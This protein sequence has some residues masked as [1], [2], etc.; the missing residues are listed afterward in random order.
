MN[1]LLPNLKNKKGMLLIIV[2]MITM[3]VTVMLAALFIHLR[4][5]ILAHDVQRAE[6]KALL[7]AQEGIAYALTEYNNAGGSWSTHDTNFVPLAKEVVL[8]TTIPHPQ[9]ADFKQAASWQDPAVQEWYYTCPIDHDNDPSTAAK[10]V[11]RL[12]AYPSSTGQIII[13]CQATTDS[14]V[15]I[16][17]TVE[18]RLNQASLF[19]YFYFFPTDHT[20]GSATYNGHNYGGIHVNGDILLKGQQNFY[21]LT[22]FSCGSESAGKGYIRTN[23]NSQFADPKNYAAEYASLSSTPKYPAALAGNVFYGINEYHFDAPASGWTQF[24]FGE[25][26]NPASWV[27]GY[28]ERTLDSSSLGVDATWE[29]DKYAGAPQGSYA[30]HFAV[31]DNYLK[32]LAINEL[33]Y[34]STSD[35]S[36]PKAI[37]ENAQQIEFFDPKNNRN[38]RLAEAEAFR[39]AYKLEKEGY[40]INWTD[41]W[42]DWKSNHVSDYSTYYSDGTFSG[43]K[44]QWERRYWMAR[45]NFN[46]PNDTGQNVNWEWWRDLSY[47]DERVGSGDDLF[48]AQYVYGSTGQAYQ[49][50]YLHSGEQANAWKKWV[51]K[52][53]QD[54]L[55]D[56]DDLV[57]DKTL[58]GKNPLLERETGKEITP[59]KPTVAG[60]KEKAQDNGLYIKIKSA[61]H[62]DLEVETSG[63][64][65]WTQ[66]IDD[67]TF[68]NAYNPKRDSSNKYVPS[69]VIK[70]DV[71]KLKEKVDAGE[72]DFNGIVYVENF[73]DTDN[74]TGVML[75]NAESLPAGGLTLTTPLNVYLKGNFNLDPSGEDF[76]GDGKNERPAD[77][78]TVIQ[79]AIER[80]DYL[81]SA[82]DLIWQPA[83]VISNR[84]VYAV[85]DDFPEPQYMPLPNSHNSQYYDY[86]YGYTDQQ[87]LYDPYYGYATGEESE[88]SWMPTPEEVNRTSYPTIYDWFRLSGESLPDRW[89]RQWADSEWGSWGDNKVFYYNDGG[90]EKFILAQDLRNE[91]YDKIGTAYSNEYRYSASKPESTPQL[92]NQ[93]SSKQIYNL[94]IVTPYQTEPY[95][96]ESWDSNTLV[97]NSAFIQL[98]NESGYIKNLPSQSYASGSRVRSP[99]NPL[100]TYETR[101]GKDNPTL[102][103]GDF[104]GTSGSSWRIVDNDDFQF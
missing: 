24:K 84:A 45:Y 49:R 78:A 72:L 76:D 100:Y 52:Y 8:S 64:V 86:A 103:P 38:Q 18:Y 75:F 31:A 25:E 11:F 67:K 30:V 48:P 34:N 71:A 4:V 29:F 13:L 93:V 6:A 68:Y 91:L 98:P 50:Y 12:K 16:L 62:N 95:V 53:S 83:A 66:F 70:I 5:A 104:L 55:L 9:G 57:H 63:E 90:T 74:S 1:L 101:F 92:T 20:F 56:W 82:S 17:K 97:V 37:F 41:F 27:T 79:S 22:D 46:S 28:L 60:Y 14:L 32:D 80:K 77:D 59:P 40:T 36:G 87:L 99:G 10:E 94:G 102:P 58:G 44:P 33:V 2:Y 35:R 61:G 39:F 21:F 88:L 3:V 81:H 7:Y 69:R 65:N 85:S 54:N 47:A 89:T 73:D 96:L 42:N 51:D 19:Q 26:K 23:L 15:P 43:D